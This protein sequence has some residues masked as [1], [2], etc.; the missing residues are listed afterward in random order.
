MALEEDPMMEQ[1]EELV[2]AQFQPYLRPRKA[3][4]LGA[5]HLRPEL[6]EQIFQA[7][8]GQAILEHV[9]R[10]ADPEMEQ[11]EGLV[12]V[13]FRPYLRPRKAEQ[14]GASHLRSE[15]QEQII[16]AEQGQA[17]L[18]HVE[19]VADPEM[20]QEEGLV[21]VQIQPYPRPRRAE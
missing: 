8:Q 21:E 13:Q 6:Q 14:L 3:E 9:E 12:E 20:E 16:Q 5:S 15:L 4:Q 10:A 19:R 2:E 17:V 1:E 7:E 18:E 11:E